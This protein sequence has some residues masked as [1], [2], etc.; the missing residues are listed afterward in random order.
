LQTYYVRRE[1]LQTLLDT[2]N[3]VLEAS[4]L[5]DGTVIN[6]YT[7]KDCKQTAITEDGK[8]IKDSTAAKELLPTQSGFFFGGTEYDEWYYEDLVHTKEVLEAALQDPDGR[9]DYSSSW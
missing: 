4:E 2:V 6:G 9:F 8:V 1:Q 5:V 3:N 7:Y